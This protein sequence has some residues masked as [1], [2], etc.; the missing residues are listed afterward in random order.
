[1]GPLSSDGATTLVL[2][3]SIL[4]GAVGLDELL[5][6]TEI[7]DS[8]LERGRVPIG[9][10]VVRDDA[11]D[12]VDSVLSEVRRGP[13]KNSSRGDALLIRVDLGVGQPGV[14][15]DDRMNV[16]EFD[17]VATRHLS[18]NRTRCRVEPDYCPNRHSRHLSYSAQTRATALELSIKKW[19]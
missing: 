11:L 1:M 3:L 18:C 15:I 7:G 19:A 2:A 10:R 8:L 13:D 4:S 5:F 16:V 14:I 17:P 6:G 9:E 12:V